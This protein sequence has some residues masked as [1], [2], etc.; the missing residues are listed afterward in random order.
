MAGIRH[1]HLLL[2]LCA[3]AALGGL[4]VTRLGY[5]N[6]DVNFSRFRDIVQDRDQDSDAFSDVVLVKPTPSKRMTLVFVICEGHFDLGIVAVKSAVAYSTSRLHLVVIADKRNEEKMR[7]EYSSWPDSVKKRV[8][9]DVKPV[10][11]P[12][13]NYH[14]WWAM[15]RP[16][17]TQRLFLPS[18]LPDEDAVIYVDTDV[19]F[20]HPVEDFWRK[21]YA[22]NEWQMAGMAP[23]TEDFKKNYYLIKGLHPFVQP[24]ALNAGLLMMNLTRMRAFG[25]ERR[26]LELKREFEGRIPFADQDLLNILFTRY[27]QG[28]F[29]FTCRWNFRGEHCQ[30]DALCTDGPVAVVHASRK[31]IS[32]KL[33]PAFVT[34]HQ[35]MQKFKL[36]QRLVDGFILPVK[37][38][39][40]NARPTGCTKELTKQLPLLTLSASRVDNTTARADSMIAP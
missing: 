39:L 3:L 27:P 36:G 32:E 34:L 35:A 17:A 31:M 33:E 21:F 24:F 1:T 2:G 4:L 10:W 22:M 13:E 11:F 19:V 9:C 23:E 26:L 18:M 15:F 6:V 38:G 30:G 16:C 8:S 12:K 37:E 28:I 14:Q 7:R 20:L 25:I 5:I 40:Q 29:T